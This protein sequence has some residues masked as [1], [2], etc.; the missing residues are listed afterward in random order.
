MAA[1]TCGGCADAAQAALTALAKALAE[2]FG[3]TGVRVV[4]VPPGPV[5]T[6]VLIDGGLVKTA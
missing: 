6:A 4:T 1:P 3:P 2:E 5:R